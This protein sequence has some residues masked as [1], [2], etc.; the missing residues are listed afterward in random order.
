VI[1]DDFKTVAICFN[2]FVC[3]KVYLDMH[4][5]SACI[6]LFTLELLKFYGSHHK[7]YAD[8]EGKS[9]ACYRYYGRPM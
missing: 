5:M 9:I 7:D 1:L 4:I 3:G 6:L 2:E 8:C